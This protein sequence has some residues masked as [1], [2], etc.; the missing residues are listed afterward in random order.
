MVSKRTQKR[1]R[2]IGAAI[3]AAH[4]ISIGMP[5]VILD[6]PLSYDGDRLV[7][8][9]PKARAALDGERLRRR[10]E[11][12][13]Q[14]LGRQAE[15][16]NLVRGF[17]VS[18]GRGERERAT[19]PARVR[20][21]RNDQDPAR[22]ADD[23][24]AILGVPRDA[25]DEDIRRTFRRLAKEL[26]PDLNPANKMA[27]EERFKKV[28]GAYDILGDAEKR[29]AFDRGE[30]DA[31]GEPRR[32]F[33]R[34][35]AGAYAAGARA[36]GA[37]PFEEPGFGDIFADLFGGPRP[38]ARNGF[39]MRGQDARYTLEVDF[40]E[41]VDGARKRVTLPEGGMLDLNVP[42]GVADGQVLRLKGKGAPG[43]RGGEPGDALVEIKVRAH[44][45]LQARRRRH[46]HRPADHDRRGGARR[47]HRGADGLGARAA[48][49]AE[50]HELRAGV[51]PEGQGGQE[52]DHGHDRRRARDGTHRAAAGDRREPVV[53]LLG[54]APEAPLRPRPAVKAP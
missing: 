38:A 18:N 45:Q 4:M 14:L 15:I 6:T 25:T 41:A 49:A 39:G 32:G 1:A 42:Q 30:I 48:D 44:A 53:L 5:G 33:Y 3:R 7:L 19:I 52:P 28:S 37:P 47:A 13:A 26:H 12:L 50:R 46:P 16:A 29:R 23:P 24:Y 21:D 31:R 40:V 51:P 17:G 8:T 20:A 34:P 35:H 9:L 10:F 43:L 54:V 2:I 11:S 27:S 22:M 36:P